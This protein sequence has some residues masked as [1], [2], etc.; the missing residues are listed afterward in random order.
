M[1][2]LFGWAFL[3]WGTLLLASTVVHALEGGLGPALRELV[4]GRESSAWAWGNLV[5]VALAS[6]A[7]P[8]AAAVALRLRWARPQSPE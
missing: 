2:L 7:W 3:L 5:A 1:A 8:L 6:I 4:P